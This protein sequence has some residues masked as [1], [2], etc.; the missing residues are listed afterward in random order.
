MSLPLAAPSLPRVFP[1]RYRG[2]AVL[3][4][5]CFYVLAA[6]CLYVLAAGCLYVLAA[7]CLHVLAAGCWAVA[8]AERVLACCQWGTGAAQAPLFLSRTPCNQYRRQ[9]SGPRCPPSGKEEQA[10]HLSLLTG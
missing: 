9:S 4:D 7:G 6:G 3:S 1:S 2:N 5:G 8:N 10:A